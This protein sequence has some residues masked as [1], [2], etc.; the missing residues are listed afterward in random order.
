VAIPPSGG[1]PRMLFCL[2]KGALLSIGV[3]SNEKDVAFA[4]RPWSS[5]AL[6]QFGPTGSGSCTVADGLTQLGLLRRLAARNDTERKTSSY[7]T[8]RTRIFDPISFRR[9]RTPGAFALGAAALADIELLH[10][11]RLAF[12]AEALR[13]SVI[14]ENRVSKQSQW[15]QLL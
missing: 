10:H 4:S 13:K 11:L 14:D 2:R 5:R 7:G 1:Q 12:L 15:T 9:L 3:S 6:F 8:G